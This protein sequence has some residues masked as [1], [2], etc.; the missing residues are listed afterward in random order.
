M[1]KIFCVLLCILMVA[2]LAGCVPGEM[3]SGTGAGSEIQ[4]N[5]T[6]IQAPSEEDGLYHIWV[7]AMPDMPMQMRPEKHYCFEDRDRYDSLTPPRQYQITVDGETIVGELSVYLYPLLSVYPEYHYKFHGG[8]FSVTPEGVLT[9]YTRKDRRTEGEPFVSQ[10]DCREK[11]E[12]FLSTWVTDLANYQCQVEEEEDCWLF[13]YK[14]YIGGIEAAEAYSV[15]M[16]KTGEVIEYYGSHVGQVPADAVLPLDME[17]VR[18]SVTHALDQMYQ[19]ATYSRIEYAQPQVFMVSVTK[20]GVVGLICEL[21][22]NCY[23]DGENYKT[24]SCIVFIT[25]EDLT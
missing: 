6:T 1:K 7:I 18:M 23:T 11:A 14:K 20:D 4:T 13:R 8:N 19:Q 10:E 5:P 9:K 3:T 17:K 21:V 24:E 15:R 16:Y 2:A 12:V 22:A 25:R